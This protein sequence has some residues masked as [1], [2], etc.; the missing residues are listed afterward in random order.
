MDLLPHIEDS[1][2]LDK[3]VRTVDHS[4]QVIRE[5]TEE[6]GNLEEAILHPSSTSSAPVLD[7]RA[8]LR[9]LRD[10]SRALLYLHTPGGAKG[11]IFHRDVKP[12]NILLD[13]HANAKLSDVGGSPNLKPSP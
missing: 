5:G 10:A 8:R 13:A 1:A 11:V 9:V 6:G 12:T 7:W 3:C 4:S 2:H